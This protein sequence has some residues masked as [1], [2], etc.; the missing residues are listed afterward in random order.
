M[1]LSRFDS[2]TRAE[3]GVDFLLTDPVTK[4]DGAAA[5]TLYGAD[6]AV[7]KGVRKE[8][9][10]HNKSLGRAPSTEEQEDQ[11]NEILARCTKGWRG[12]LDDDGDEIPFSQAKAKEI[13]AAYPEFKD[14]VS[15]FIF[16]RTNFFGNA[17][18]N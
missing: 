3:A 12:L 5:I 13:Y 11:V 6:S 16:T 7:H 8:I 14:R 4:A 18:G 9:E 10:A 15:V 1:K 2:V 17:S